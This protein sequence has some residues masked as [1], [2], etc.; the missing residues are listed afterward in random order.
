MAWNPRFDL[1]LKFGESGELWLKLL[2]APDG[3]KIEVKTERDAWFTTGNV[4]FEFESRGK[5]SGI[6]VTEADYWFHLLSFE[7]KI[8]GAY[9]FR[10]HELKVF[11]RKVYL[12]PSD[13]GARV[14]VGGDNNSSKIII[15]PIKQLHR[16]N[17]LQ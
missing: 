3:A 2:G 6:S 15:V 16:V 5:K 8:V 1:D 7:G 4:V 10:V 13:Y 12:R 14:S 9:G 11:L 17:L